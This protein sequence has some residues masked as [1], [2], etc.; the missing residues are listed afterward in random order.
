MANRTSRDV[1]IAR[2]PRVERESQAKPGFDGRHV[3]VAPALDE[4]SA[5]QRADLRTSEALEQRHAPI[6]VRIARG[7]GAH[8]DE[9]GGMGRMARG[10][11][12]G[13]RAAERG[14]VDDRMRDPER[15]AECA[16]VVGPP[17][18]GPGLRRAEIAAAV[19]AMVEEDDLGDV[20]QRGERGLVDRVIQ[21]RAAVE[22]EE[23]RLLPHHGAVGHEARAFH[24]EEEP[25]PVDDDAHLSRG[26]C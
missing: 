18:Q 12:E 3:S 17:R 7:L 21:A 13:H 24:V 25:H 10:V 23:R 1:R 9:L 15:V 20:G 4:A 2:R 5:R 8:Q 26:S 22:Q 11:R 16:D 14:A 19:A 6:Q